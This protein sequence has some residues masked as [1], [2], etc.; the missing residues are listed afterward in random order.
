M[1]STARS[2]SSAS[3][4]KEVRVKV[5]VRCRP[6]NEE[7]KKKDGLPIVAVRHN[8]QVAIS[9]HS[10]Q[11]KV[12]KAY[13][14][15]TAYGPETTQEDLYDHSIR[16]IVDEV[17]N[18]YNCTVFAYGQTGTGKTF[19]MEGNRDADSDGLQSSSGVVAR[20]VHQVFT[21]LKNSST[22]EY[23]VRVSCIELY[24]EE[25]TDLFAEEPDKKLRIFDD[26]TAREGM[27]KGIVIANLEE[28]IVTNVKEVLSLL[29]TSQAKRRTAETLMNKF[30]SRSHTIFTITIHTKESTPDGEDL[31]KFGKLNLVDLAGS[32]NVGKSGAV[33]ERKKEA[34]M[35]NTSLLTLGRVITAL[36]DHQP[37]IPYR[38]SKL[39]RLLQDSLGGRTMTCVIATVGPFAGSI[40]ETLSTLD[41]ANRAKNIKNRPEVN[42]M[43]SKRTVIK[44]YTQEIKR[45]KDELQAARA[46]DG[47]YMPIEAHEE[48][49]TQI[50]QQNARI[51]ELD[52]LLEERLKEFEKLQEMFQ[53]KE[54]ELADETEAHAVTRSKLMRTRATLQDTHFKLKKTKVDLV[55]HQSVVQEKDT[56]ETLMHGQAQSLLHTSMGMK[57]NISKLFSKI[58]RKEDV[59]T[60]NRSALARM[61]RGMA[62]S[63]Q[64]MDESMQEVRDGMVEKSEAL[65]QASAAMQQLHDSRMQGLFRTVEGMMGGLMRG[66]SEKAAEMETMLQSLTQSTS[67]TCTD[68]TSKAEGVQQKVEETISTLKSDFSTAVS[69]LQQAQTQLRGLSSSWKAGFEELASNLCSA[70]TESSEKTA[71]LMTAMQTELLHPMKKASSAFATQ[72]AS[73]QE[74]EEDMM[75]EEEE[76]KNE[77]LRSITALVQ[78]SFSESRSSLQDKITLRKRVAQQERKDAEKAVESGTSLFEQV[79]TASAESASR[80]NSIADSVRNASVTVDSAIVQSADSVSNTAA[81]A[82]ESG[83]KTADAAVAALTAAVKEMRATN[84]GLTSTVTTSH[85]NVEGMAKAMVEGAQEKANQLGASLSSHL[86]DGQADSLRAAVGSYNVEM[87]KE[88]E[89]TKN[90]VLNGV[91]GLSQSRT[92]CEEH[93][94]DYTKSYKEYTATGETPAKQHIELPSAVH[95]PAPGAA[96]L[97]AIR[98]GRNPA[99]WPR[100][101]DFEVH[102][103]VELDAVLSEGEEEEE[104]EEETS[105]TAVEL[106]DIGMDV[107]DDEGEQVRGETSG[108]ASLSRS[109]SN[110]SSGSDSSQPKAPKTPSM[111]PRLASSSNLRSLAADGGEKENA[112]NAN[113]RPSPRARKTARTLRTFGQVQNSKN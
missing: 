82:L 103:D 108:H 6:M 95:S 22:E 25:L 15:D 66:V 48:M 30:S 21:H 70:V 85:T 90:G 18:G 97:D 50:E 40:E 47:V 91:S 31:V 80:F 100:R 1:S 54:E 8:N 113:E 9:T 98:T 38:E 81:H 104:R 69:Q 110:L 35:I 74:M 16:P 20:A 68:A 14:F 63:F 36:V 24:N 62:A 79:S 29:D 34:G 64:S 10:G 72:Q 71:Q 87:Q 94:Q 77:L 45:L 76:R 101:E 75:R 4:E 96:L 59:F 7:E 107:V 17:L 61:Q 73:L 57:E 88:V 92:E 46:K 99:D 23:N 86:F 111:I 19:T 52:A 26:N 51:E 32:E 83:Q 55:D 41:Y 49:T 78:T 56:R 13:T 44:E 2:S 102:S 43:M 53:N 28:K 58:E 93:L 65:I 39:T 106:S 84:T 11:R 12:Q 42:Q 33:N 67:T 37:H 5:I 112:V 105:L 60:H 89:N 109:I 3:H 27:K